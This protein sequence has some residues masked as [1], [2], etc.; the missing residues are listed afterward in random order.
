MSE[1]DFRRH[2]KV[3]NSISKLSIRSLSL[4]PM[5][6]RNINKSQLFNSFLSILNPKSKIPSSLNK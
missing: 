2:R 5:D 3:E 6:Q 4:L 1:N